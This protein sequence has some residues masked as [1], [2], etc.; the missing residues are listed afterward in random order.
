[1]NLVALKQILEQTTPNQ[2]KLVND[3]DPACDICLKSKHQQKVT[4]TEATRAKIPFELIHSDSCGSIARSI[5]GSAYYIVFIDDCTRHT[6][7]YFLLTKSAEEVSSKFQHFKAWVTAQG[8]RI[9]RFRCDNGRG[10]YSNKTFQKILGDSGITFEP[11]PPYTQHKNGVSERMIRTLNTKARSMLLDAKLPK[12]FWAEAIATAAYLHQ[13]SPSNSLEGLTPYELLTGDKPQ[14]HHLR[15]FG[16]IVYKYI[17]KDQRKNGKFG[18]RSKPCMLLG[19]VHKTTKIWRI[20]DF[21]AGP[22]QRGAAIKCSSVVF[23]EDENAYTRNIAT[24]DSLDSDSDEDLS[25]IDELEDP[26]N[27]DYHPFKSDNLNSGPQATVDEINDKAL[28]DDL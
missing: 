5:G 11:A 13:R 14:L 1:M 9:R 27:G 8:Y 21:Q 2:L 7:V 15:R 24:S 4:R 22:Y 17:P 10:E 3:H 18:E 25:G 26:N 20:W 16:C 23:K 12:K 19:Y 6:E 28:N